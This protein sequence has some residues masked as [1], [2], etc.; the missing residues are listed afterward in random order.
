MYTI[1]KRCSNTVKAYQLG[2]QHDVIQRLIAQGRIRDNGDGTYRV[3][4]REVHSSDADGQLAKAGDW[5]KLDSGGFP[6]P[7]D[8]EFFK[9]NHRHIDGDDYQQIPQTLQA[10][11]A[12]RGELETCPEVQYLIT[13]NRL[14]VH[15]DSEDSRY[16]ADLWGT[17]EHAAADAVIVFYNGSIQYDDAGD[18]CRIGDF[19]FV[20]R[21]EFERTYVVCGDG[22]DGHYIGNI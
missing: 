15:E 10:W 5:I 17:T 4:S 7:N 8:Q 18:I 12:D 2:S 13:H 14:Q 1:R 21:A 9:A 6:Y 3:F 20:A 11:D 16:M 22:A 19:N